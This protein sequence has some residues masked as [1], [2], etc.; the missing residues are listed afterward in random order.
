MGCSPL[1]IGLHERAELVRM[2]EAPSTGFNYAQM[3]GLCVCVCVVERMKRDGRN[4]CVLWGRIN[5][6]RKDAGGG[7]ER[8]PLSSASSITLAS[9][10]QCSLV[11]TA[12]GTAGI[13]CVGTAISRWVI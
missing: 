9:S 3:L 11:A 13:F 1:R 8:R 7:G 2:S 10:K 12:A 4:R 6:R 5:E